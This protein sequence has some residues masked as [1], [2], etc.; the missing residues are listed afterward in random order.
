MLFICTSLSLSDSPLVLF[1]AVA[2]PLGEPGFDPGVLGGDV[3]VLVFLFDR[4]EEEEGEE[5]DAKPAV[6][7]RCCI[8]ALTIRSRLE[9]SKVESRDN[10]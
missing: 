6:A 3:P 1:L 10:L 2:A 4:E 7:K 9:T 8:K 5:E